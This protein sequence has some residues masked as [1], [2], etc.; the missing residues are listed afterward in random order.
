MKKIIIFVGLLSMILLLSGCQMNV[1][2]G[3]HHYIVEPFASLIHL[4]ATLFSGSYG[5]AIIVLTL[6]IRLVLAPLMIKQMINQNEMREKMERVKPEMQEIQAKIKQSK[7]AKEQRELQQDMMALYKKHGINPLSIGCLPILIQ[8]P[9]LSAF[10]FAIRG[11]HAIASHTFLWFSLGGPSLV[12]T[13]LA[14]LIYYVQFRV[15]QTMMTVQPEQGQ[16]MKMMGFMSPLMIVMFSF[17]SPAAL[18][19]YW[20]VGGAF[21]IVQTYVTKWIITRQKQ[22]AEI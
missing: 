2:T 10:Y 11:S 6:I 1:G 18:P 4:T 14:G 16:T 19:L 21:L 22:T 8:M 15:Q 5:I 12:L 17:N 9:I 7:D 20:I 3:F 13:I